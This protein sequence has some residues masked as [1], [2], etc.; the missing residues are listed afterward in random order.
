[1]TLAVAFAFCPSFV[2]LFSTS[3]SGSSPF[4][5][6]FIQLS[7]LHLDHVSLFRLLSHKVKLRHVA[8][9]FEVAVQAHVGRILLQPQLIKE[10]L[11]LERFSFTQS[12]PLQLHKSKFAPGCG[13]LTFARAALLRVGVG[14]A[15]VTGRLKRK[16]LSTNRRRATTT[17]TTTF[18]SITGISGRTCFRWLTSTRRQ[19]RVV[20]QCHRLDP[21]LLVVAIRGKTRMPLRQ[22][23]AYQ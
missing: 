12:L 2:F 15:G 14:I 21:F 18:T 3:G 11:F 23:P 1:M 8:H 6:S 7:Y 16:R 5:R 9:F 10:V 20:R 13:R 22:V 17:T 4:H 19:V